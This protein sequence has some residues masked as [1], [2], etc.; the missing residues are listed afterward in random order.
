MSVLTQLAALDVPLKKICYRPLQ[1][2][3]P[4]WHSEFVRL[5]RTVM[6][7]LV[8]VDATYANVDAELTWAQ[9][10]ALCTEH[11]A[12]VCIYSNPYHW[13]GY[14]NTDASLNEDDTTAG[15]GISDDDHRAQIQ[16]YVDIIKTAADAQGFTVRTVLL[17]TERFSAA[18][19]TAGNAAHNASLNLKLSSVYD[20]FKTAFGAD[21]NPGAST[22]A[23]V[24]GF[25]GLPAI[26]PESNEQASTVP[27]AMTY[28]GAASPFPAPAGWGLEA[29][30][31][32]PYD[33][34]DD[35]P[36]GGYTAGSTTPWLP[37]VICPVLYF[38]NEPTTI[39]FCQ[40]WSHNFTKGGYGAT[41]PIIPFLAMGQ[42]RVRSYD[43]WYGI[44]G[45]CSYSTDYSKL[46]GYVMNNA[47]EYD[48]PG[49]EERW[50]FENSEIMMWPAPN[51]AFAPSYMEHFVAYC[52][53]AAD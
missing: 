51:D 40:Q 30:A 15:G 23:A 52:Q 12:Q 7:E 16:A 28:E 11:S 20:I 38:P 46:Y 8:L 47:G 21:D 34:T 2:P 3:L 48:T 53:G 25:Y 45:P 18:S 6:V 24:V 13:G 9:V 17:D 50:F 27:N 49:T 35:D 4:E 5:T 33:E 1:A 41:K 37:D 36:S 29:W 39:Q 26:R 14:T 31:M 10:G 32:N 44:L 42:A 22:A 43:D 19:N